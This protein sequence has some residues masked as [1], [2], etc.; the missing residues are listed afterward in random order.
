MSLK[1]VFLG[2]RGSLQSDDGSNTSLLVAAEDR[3]LLIDC[4][5]NLGL[6]VRE[7]VD[8]LIITH[9]HVDHLY[10]LP[11]LIH[12]MWISGRRKT[13]VIHAAREVLDQVEKL[14]GVFDLRNKNGM[15]PMILQPLDLMEWGSLEVAPFQTD[16][17]RSSYGLVITSGEVKIA[18][19]SDT[20]PVK[21]IKPLEGAAV[22]IT[23][24]SG[25]ACEEEALVK[26]G[27]Q[28]GQDAAC[29]AALAGVE[30]LY[31]VHLP[32]DDLKVEA[33]EREARDIFPG[34]Y[35]ARPFM[36]ICL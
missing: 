18:Y 25:C 23:E 11:S 13:L 16:H 28:S 26:K 24:A 34:S 17:T 1:I 3:S 5:G 8:D 21:D 7:E 9:E 19:T 33:I 2:V 31:L 12:Q 6:A 4:S 32:D 29:L 10:G 22:L 27:H 20:R 15:F 36:E 14:I 30:E 35:A